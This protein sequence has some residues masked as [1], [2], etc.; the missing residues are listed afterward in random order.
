[1]TDQ[2]RE[3]PT[4][5]PLP[6]SER[7]KHVILSLT[8]PPASHADVTFYLVSALFPFVDSLSKCHLRPETKAKIRK[9]RE[10]LDKDLKD[11]AE[12]EKK[13]EVRLIARTLRFG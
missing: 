12:R 3:R 7:E 8:A 11:E 5:G 10:D 9:I 13:E 1:V 2:P 4:N 6:V